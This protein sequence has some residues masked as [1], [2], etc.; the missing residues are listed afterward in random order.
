MLLLPGEEPTAA[1]IEHVEETVSRRRTSG[2]G[3]GEPGQPLPDRPAL[4]EACAVP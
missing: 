2:R 3:T 1:G 4:W